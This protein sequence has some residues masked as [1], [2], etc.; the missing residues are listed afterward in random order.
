MKV[1]DLQI[2][3]MQRAQALMQQRLKQAEDAINEYMANPILDPT[4]H[5]LP[6]ST[7]A[8]SV[9]RQPIPNSRRLEHT[10]PADVTTQ[11][12]TQLDDLE[13]LDFTVLAYAFAYHT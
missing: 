3:A 6:A 10:I 11:R 5:T 7:T 13:L 8:T 12:S 1:K 9:L 4:S 2:E